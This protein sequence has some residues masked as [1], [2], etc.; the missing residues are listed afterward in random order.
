MAGKVNVGAARSTRGSR[1]KVDD[2]VATRKRAPRARAPKPAPA[3]AAPKVKRVRE[4]FRLPAEEQ[5]QIARL[6]ARA[7]ELG[8]PARKSEVLRAGLQALVAAGDE[9]LRTLLDALAPVGRRKRG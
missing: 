2:E 5:A 4:S 9:E 6:K 7:A 8:R 1:S 3:P